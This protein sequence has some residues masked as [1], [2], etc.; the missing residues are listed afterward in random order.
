MWDALQLIE[1]QP[2]L[3]V[4]VPDPGKHVVIALPKIRGVAKQTAGVNLAA[5]QYTERH[6]HCYLK[7][8]FPQISL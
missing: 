6:L 1:A 2:K 4:V 7:L 3:Q 8:F 5:P